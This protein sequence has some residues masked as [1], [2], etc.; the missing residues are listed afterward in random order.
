MRLGAPIFAD[1]ST[2]DAWIQAV[3]SKSYRAANCPLEPNASDEAV[4]DYARAARRADILIAEVGAWSNPLSP[5]EQERRAA[6]EKCKNSLDLAERIGAHHCVNISGSRSKQWDGPHPDNL[7]EETFEMIVQTTREIVDA[8]RPT[9]TFYTLET[10]PWAFPDSPQ[11]YLRLIEAIDRPGFGVHLDPVNMM[12]SPYRFFGNA[13]FLRECFSVLGPHIKGAHAKDITL[14]THLT[15]HLD[16]ARPGQGSLDYRVLLGEMN[17]LDADVPL[18]LE[19]LPGE[20]DYDLAA[21]FVRSVADE[22]G[23]SL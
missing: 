23:L 20:D 13:D 3:Q 15:V 17:K 6:I 5:D 14:G 12:N 11:S 18:M 21:A 10:M 16:E 22:L 8:V 9:R 19:H 1:K 4:R 2:P 7:S